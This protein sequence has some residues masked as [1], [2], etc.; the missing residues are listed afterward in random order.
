MILIYLKRW[1]CR[2]SL[3]YA[4]RAL[5]PP[6]VNST[7]YNRDKC[8]VRRDVPPAS[9]PPTVERAMHEKWRGF[10]RYERHH[11]G[12]KAPKPCG[13]EAYLN[14]PALV[15]AIGYDFEIARLKSTLSAPCCGNRSFERTGICQHK[16]RPVVAS[17]CC[18]Q[19][20]PFPFP[21]WAL[22]LPWP[23]DGLLAAAPLAPLD[24]ALSA[25]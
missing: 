21:L 3:A 11:R 24:A 22:W 19:G 16:A 10:I 15:A 20:R 7:R 6:L 18:S 23:L 1:C 17:R 13:I 5:N 12:L 4:P 25:A 14:L 2:Q 8:Q 9:M